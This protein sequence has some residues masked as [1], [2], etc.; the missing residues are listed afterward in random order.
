MGPN[1]GVD[2]GALST[3]VHG[4]RPRP[5]HGPL[6]SS[7]HAE[8]DSDGYVFTRIT[9]RVTSRDDVISLIK[10]MGLEPRTTG[11]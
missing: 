9:N 4:L 2:E 5:A 11:I 10:N 1:C 6:C 8:P 3:K 7:S